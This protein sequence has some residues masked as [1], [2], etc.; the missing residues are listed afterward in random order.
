M[1]RGV[2]PGSRRSGTTERSAAI[3]MTIRRMPLP[4]GPPRRNFVK[5]IPIGVVDTTTAGLCG[6]LDRLR[7]K[8]DDHWNVLSHVVQG[9]TAEQH[10]DRAIEQQR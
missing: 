6:A 8:T 7:L 9:S 5:K 2:E 3:E 1:P 4:P 10:S